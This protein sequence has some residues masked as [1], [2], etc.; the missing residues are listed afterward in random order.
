MARRRRPKR[1][2]YLVDPGVEETRR[3]PGDTF[4]ENGVTYIV[5]LDG[6]AYPLPAV[7]SQE[8]PPPPG[9]GRSEDGSLIYL[10]GDKPWYFVDG[11]WTTEQGG[12]TGASGIDWSTYF[13]HWGLPLDVVAVIDRIF[14]ETDDAA[15]AAAK[16]LAFIRGT[17][18]YARTFPGIQEGLRNGTVRD[19]ADYRSQLTAANWYARQ[20]LGRDITADE[21]AGILREGIT[22]DIYGK[23]LAG[24]AYTNAYGPE[25]QYAAGNFGTGAEGELSPSELKAYG[26]QQAGLGSGT[27]ALLQRRIED[28][29]RRVQRAFEGTL[30][31]PGLSRSG[32]GKVRSGAGPADVGI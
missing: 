9:Y 27:G 22:P 15:V 3:K 2:G 20:Y 16:A 19:E 17:E 11:R 29:F 23:R 13:G 31:T 10:G 21:F 5:A 14:R 1:Q 18:W 24:A 28:A 30:A 7:P 8:G 26:E 4:T 6:N 25:I 32:T 12:G